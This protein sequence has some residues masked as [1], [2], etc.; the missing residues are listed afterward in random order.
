M[1]PQ[2]IYALPCNA[3]LTQPSY[4]NR[5]IFQPA[6]PRSFALL[7]IPTLS[8]TNYH[9]FGGRLNYGSFNVFALYSSNGETPRKTCRRDATKNPSAPLRRACAGA[10]RI[11]E[12]IFSRRKSG[13][14]GVAE[15]RTPPT[16]AIT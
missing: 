3:F 11:T 5:P 13:R 7:R 9:S 16:S 8:P 12:T 15:H 10:L 4:R 2:C 14:E 6:L 1:I